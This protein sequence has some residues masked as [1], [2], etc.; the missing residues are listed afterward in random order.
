MTTRLFHEK[1]MNAVLRR[2]SP[3]RSALRS[4]TERL[5]QI[6]KLNKHVYRVQL[7]HVRIPQALRND[8]SLIHVQ[9]NVTLEITNICIRNETERK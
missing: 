2:F 8:L 5:M 3:L 9:W 6:F 1:S 4:E 7:P